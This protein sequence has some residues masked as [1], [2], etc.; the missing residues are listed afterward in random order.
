MVVEEGF[1]LIKTLARAGF[2][3]TFY[4]L[5][6]FQQLVNWKAF[7]AGKVKDFLDFIVIGHGISGQ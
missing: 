5:M 4:L 7:H 2:T 3:S 1:S 6:S